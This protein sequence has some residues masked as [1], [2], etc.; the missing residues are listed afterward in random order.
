MKKTLQRTDVIK[1]ALT[2]STTLMDEML[3]QHKVFRDYEKKWAELKHAKDTNQVVLPLPL[4]LL[5]GLVT[6]TKKLYGDPPGDTRKKF[7]EFLEKGHDIID[8]LGFLMFPVTLDSDY[9]LQKIKDAY[10]GTSAEGCLDD[11]LDN[12]KLDGGEKLADF[13]KGTNG[14]LK[15]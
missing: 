3:T 9:E 2:A 11:V 10:K 14:E 5:I 12:A 4:V 13:L 15:H 1:D 6:A 8:T 7:K